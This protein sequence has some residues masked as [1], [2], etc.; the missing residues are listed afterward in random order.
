MKVEESEIEENTPMCTPCQLRKQTLY[1]FQ[2][3]ICKHQ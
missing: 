3:A 1:N 2:L